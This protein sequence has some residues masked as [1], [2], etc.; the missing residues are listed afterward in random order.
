MQEGECENLR[1]VIF[2]DKD[3]ENF[4]HKAIAISDRTIRRGSST[5]Q[6]DDP[7]NIQ[8]TSGTTGFPK[9][10]TLSHYNILNNAYFTGKRLHY[11]EAG[12]SLHTSSFVSL[13]WYGHWQPVLH[14]RRRL[15]RSSF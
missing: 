6:F 2:L 8:Y 4:L 13:F 5:L 1:E 14:F 15:H 10:V 11:T 3:W 9:G 12:Y 7:I